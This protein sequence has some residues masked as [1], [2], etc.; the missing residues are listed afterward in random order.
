MLHTEDRR[1]YLRGTDFVFDLGWW[2]SF[3]K[4]QIC[5]YFAEKEFSTT[6]VE[7]VSCCINFRKYQHVFCIFCH[8]MAQIVEIFPH[9]DEDSITLHG[10]YYDC[11][12]PG[13]AGSLGISS[14]GIDLLVILEYSGFSAGRVK[15]DDV[16]HII[17]AYTSEDHKSNLVFCVW[18]GQGSIL[19]T[20]TQRSFVLYSMVIILSHH[21]ELVCTI[22]RDCYVCV[23]MM[24][25]SSGNIFLVTGPLCR[26]YIDTSDFP[27]QRPVT[28]SFDV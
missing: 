15:L 5:L 28:R 3:T 8:L 21:V 20:R 12:W 18:C 4:M 7:T 11:W 22:L 23:F 19:H 2:I 16:F 27:A 6:G 17:L 24:A 10:Q 26:E 25:P 9:Q 13:D 14:H 1:T